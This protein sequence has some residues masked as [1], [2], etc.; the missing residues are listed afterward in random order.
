M[1]VHA[2]LG[3]AGRAR[4]EGDEADVLGCRRHGGEI[5]RL[6]RDQAGEVVVAVAPHTDDRKP[7]VNAVE[8]VPPAV[9]AQGEVDV[10]R[11][12]D[13]PQLAGPQQGHGGHRH[14]PGLD[15]G[16]PAGDQPRIVRSS[17]QDPVAG[18]QL[19]ILDQHPGDPV[20][21]LAHLAVGPGAV[22]APQARPVGSEA[23]GRA[24]EQFDGGVEHL[25]V[26]ELR[27]GEDQI[28]PGR[29]GRQMVTGEGV[30]VGSTRDC[31][32][33]SRRV[34]LV[35]WVGPRRWQDLISAR[36]RSSGIRPLPTVSG[37][38]RDGQWSR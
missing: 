36:C 17:Q 26:A 10:G 37:A 9:V 16:Q 15:D 1:A 31:Q 33:R 18:Y 23:L 27:E 4:C 28:R 21:G 25:R 8:L 11:V 32:G 38:G 29:P 20:D 13:R 24:V 7:A 30:D 2:A 14:G 3:L 19:E 6:R 34:R 12:H 35:A 5:R 22:L